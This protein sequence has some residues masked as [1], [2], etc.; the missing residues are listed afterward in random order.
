[1]MVGLQPYC[2]FR[3]A[4]PARSRGFPQTDRYP[5]HYPFASQPIHVTTPTPTDRQAFKA[6][7]DIRRDPL[8]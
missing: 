8:R 1:M 7:M 4:L 5:S 2:T 3:F 6:T